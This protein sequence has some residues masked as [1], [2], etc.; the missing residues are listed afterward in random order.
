MAT[1]DDILGSPD[2]LRQLIG[3]E[4]FAKTREQALNQGILQASLAALGGRG[5]VGQVI[6]QAGSAGLQG[7][8]GAFDRTLNDMVKATQISEMV[9]KQKETSCCLCHGG[10]KSQ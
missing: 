1:I 2:F 6:S 7:Y 10:R 8:Q 4:Q 3:E 9:R 5:N